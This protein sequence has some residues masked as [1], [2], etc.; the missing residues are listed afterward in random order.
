MEIGVQLGPT[1]ARKRDPL[2]VG[3]EESL[4]G[5]VRGGELP[6]G[7]FDSETFDDEIATKAMQRGLPDW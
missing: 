6:R 4:R 7:P 2:G 1:S 5:G 3:N